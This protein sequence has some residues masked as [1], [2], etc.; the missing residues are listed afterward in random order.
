VNTLP[1][2]FSGLLRT[3]Q[4]LTCAPGTF[5][6]AT[7]TALSWLRNGNPIG[8]ATAAA[9]TLKGRD[10]GK[11]IQCRVTA[12]GPGGSVVA[13]SAPKVP[14]KACIVPALVGKRLAAAR[15]DLKRANCALGTTKR[16]KS[17][18][19]PGTVLKSSPAEGR[20]LP[21]RTKVALTVARK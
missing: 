4:E 10:V 8:G 5:T 2:S 13:E 15:K 9:Y 20:N 14:A 17:S 16:R 18:R 1:P 12:T 19:K 7:S 6:G 21:A 3:G 11:A